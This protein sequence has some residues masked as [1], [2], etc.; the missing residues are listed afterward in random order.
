LDGYDQVIFA[1][2][3]N[4]NN[5]SVVNPATPPVRASKP[6]KLKLLLV[7]MIMGLGL[8]LAAPFLYELFLN[9]RLRC[10]DDWER[11]FGIQVL[12][13]FDKISFGTA[14]T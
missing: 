9:R 14:A 12:A 13:Q 3:G 6:N 7:A 11:E 4:Y 1:A 2:V 8:G 10:R 5:V